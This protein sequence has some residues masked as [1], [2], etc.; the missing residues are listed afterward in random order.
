MPI[1]TVK[2]NSSL[3]GYNTYSGKWVRRRKGQQGYVGSRAKA[4]QLK[5]AG[6][7]P[8]FLPEA[9]RNLTDFF[10]YLNVASTLHITITKIKELRLYKLSH[11]DRHLLALLHLLNIEYMRN[12]YSLDIPQCLKVEFVDPKR[13]G[14]PAIMAKDLQEGCFRGIQFYKKRGNKTLTNKQYKKVRQQKKAMKETTQ[15][16]IVEYLSRRKTAERKALP[17]S[18]QPD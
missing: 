2:N 18:E 15:H 10:G 3:S 1:K 13:G 17:R 6:E 12:M 9:V 11:K 16:S 4:A 7:L 5:R 14:L 8:A